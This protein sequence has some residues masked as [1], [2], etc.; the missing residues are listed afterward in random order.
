M[1]KPVPKIAHVVRSAGSCLRLTPLAFGNARMRRGCQRAV[2]SLK[3]GRRGTPASVSPTYRPK[4]V[5]ATTWPTV[6]KDTP[7]RAIVS[8]VWSMFRRSRSMR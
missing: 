1:R 2:S 7:R 8:W 3:N 4:V 6:G 5:A